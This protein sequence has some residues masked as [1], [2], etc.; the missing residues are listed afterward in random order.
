[1][2]RWLREKVESAIRWMSGEY[3]LERRVQSDFPWNEYW[4]KVGERPPWNDYWM[5]QAADVASRSTCLK[6][7]YGAQIT[8]PDGK[9]A[10][11]DG[12]NGAP[13]GARNCLERGYCIRKKLG[14][15]HGKMLDMCLGVDAERNAIINASTNGVKIPEGARIYV[16]G[17]DKNTGKLL[18][19]RPRIISMGAML[20]ARIGEIYYLNSDGKMVMEKACDI[21]WQLNTD[22]EKYLG[23]KRED[24]DAI[25]NLTCE[26]EK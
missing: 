15:P 20:N 2:G 19:G 21:I 7:G 13:R 4:A 6:A 1:M 22:V 10:I 3:P 16:V 25:H 18:V 24:I 11:S 26:L 23:L 17:F 5:K 9:V 12:Y 14:I 8:T